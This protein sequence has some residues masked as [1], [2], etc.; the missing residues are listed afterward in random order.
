DHS[1]DL[2]ADLGPRLRRARRAPRHRRRRHH[3]PQPPRGDERP[4]R[5]DQGPAPRHRAAGGR[6]PGRAL[7]RAHRKRPGVLRRPGPQGAPRGAQGGQLGAAVGHGRGALQ[8]H[9]PRAGHH[10][11]AGRRCRQ[12]RRRRSRGEPRARRGLQDP[13]RHRRL[14]HLLRRGRA[15]VRHG[16]QLDPAAAGGTGE[17]HRAPLLP[18]HRRRGGGA[19]AGPRQPGR[20]GRWLPAGRR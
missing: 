2:A 18:A 16:L 4:G 15:V 5:R 12:R 6:G 3:H 14:Q 17:G 1:P 20:P 11:Q 10:A 13:G 9:R 19:R 8:P 7:R